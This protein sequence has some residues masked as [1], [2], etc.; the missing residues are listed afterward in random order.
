MISSVAAELTVA[1]RELGETAEAMIRTY[2][3]LAAFQAQIRSGQ[4]QELGD[5][6][7]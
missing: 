7:S 5:A 1:D 6:L 3:N 4:L 2:G